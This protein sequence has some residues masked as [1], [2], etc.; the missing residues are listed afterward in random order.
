M[1][2]DEDDAAARGQW[3]RTR[4]LYPLGDHL[5]PSRRRFVVVRA[6]KRAAPARRTLDEAVE[7]LAWL[8]RDSR[9]PLALDADHYDAPD[10]WSIDVVEFA[11]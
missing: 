8:T 3:Q 9:P 7:D 11:P 5:E 2:E 4:R 10:P 1:Q 6:G